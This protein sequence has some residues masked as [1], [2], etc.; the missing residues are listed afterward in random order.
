MSVQINVTHLDHGNGVEST[1]KEQNAKW[2][3]SCY[4]K[5]GKSKLEHAKKQK[6]NLIKN[7]QSQTYFQTQRQ[8]RIICQH[9]YGQ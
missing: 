1:F 3:K 4:L 8:W 7:L 5:F 2:H 9:I 6:G